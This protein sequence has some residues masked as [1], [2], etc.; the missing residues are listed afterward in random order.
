MSQDP[1]QA[2]RDIMADA[3]ALLREG[4]TDKAR[5]HANNA[6]GHA[7]DALLRS[8][9][10]GGA[11]ESMALAT[12]ELHTAQMLH[13]AKLNGQGMVASGQIQRIGVEP[14]ASQDAWVE[15][16][17]EGLKNGR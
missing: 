2:A 5:R 11:A 12:Q 10:P 14:T 8:H 9:S 15:Q 3:G 17:N 7:R 4:S 13:T 6:Y 1:S 16:T